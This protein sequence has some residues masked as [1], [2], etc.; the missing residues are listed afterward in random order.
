MGICET[1]YGMFMGRDK[2]RKTEGSRYFREEQVWEDELKGEQTWSVT[3][4]QDADQYSLSVQALHVITAI[5]TIFLLNPLL[6]SV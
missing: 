5:C 4:K 2:G 3:P 1:Y 6:F